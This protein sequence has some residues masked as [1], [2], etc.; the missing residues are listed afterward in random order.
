MSGGITYNGV[1]RGDAGRIFNG[2][3]FW[4]AQQVP[5]RSDIL[6][7]VK[8]NG[9]VV[10]AL[11]KDA[12][13]LIADHARKN[14]PSGSISWKFITESVENGVVQIPD[15]Y[16]IEQAP[17]GPR[18]AASGR[19]A[20]LVRAKFTTAEDAALASWVLAHDRHLTGN[21]MYMEFETKHPRHTWQSWRDRYMK[22]LRSLP[23]AALVRLA[24]QAS[25][26]PPPQAI[27]GAQP[28]QELPDPTALMLQRQG[29]RVQQETAQQRARNRSAAQPPAAAAQ[30]PAPSPQ[31]Q[32]AEDDD[33]A[34]AG[35][36]GQL[37]D[38]LQEYC[39]EAGLRIATTQQIAGQPVELWE[40]L[41]ALSDQKLPAEEIDWLRVAEQLGYAWPDVD[42]AVRALQRCYEEKLADFL[43]IMDL[44]PTRGAGPALPRN[45]MPS[46]PP[47]RFLPAKRPLDAD[48]QELDIPTP[49]KRRRL[50]IPPEVPSTPDVDRRRW[51][52]AGAA[53][54]TTP[55]RS[56]TP[57]PGLHAHDSEQDMTPSQQ[58]QS[59][60]LNSS[61]IPP[62]FDSRPAP[63]QSP[64]AS[65]TANF[66]RR[67]IPHNFKLRPPPQQQQ[68]QS[69][70]SPFL[71][72][73]IP[74]AQPPPPPLV[75]AA[76][77]PFGKDEEVEK[78]I[79]HY[80]SLG[81]T[82]A[83]V[84]EGL[85]RTTMTL[86]LATVVMQSLHDGRGVPAHHQGVWTDGDDE[87]LRLVVG[88]GPEALETDVRDKEVMKK[89]RKARRARNRL[90]AKHGE[91][92][93]ARRIEYLKASGAWLLPPR[94]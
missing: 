58:L 82:R 17:A 94:S 41:K 32:S 75:A 38:D 8:R 7:H 53:T 65:S 57:L 54:T 92:R 81:Y 35:A 43:D 71:G 93:M 83:T 87:G 73:I 69:Q 12:D 26:E 3:K 28:E 79:Q 56:E 6:D 11:E 52:S 44:V 66:K 86:G 88:V 20:R 49:A 70:E 48:D 91:E 31:P 23:H 51:A 4:V 30:P 14:A 18:Q 84:I 21:A 25:D 5:M 55:V 16:R 2:L 13:Y 63:P 39:Q 78:H 59:E 67:V 62:R 33:A 76:R 50:M 68:Q 46:S 19:P 10:V 64:S 42:V 27:E 72:A 37:Y 1:A 90:T 74:S 36:K 22:K 60:Y 45:Q 85:K 9:G 47:A 24:S 15:R 61:P 80:E 29:E 34:D 77:R 89:V 40:L